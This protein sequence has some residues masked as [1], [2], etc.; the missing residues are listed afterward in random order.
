[1]VVPSDTILR[2]LPSLLSKG[3]FE[4]PYLGI[5]GQDITPGIIE[6]MKLPTGTHGT[7][8]VDVTANG[9]SDKAGLK[10]GT[11]TKSIDG[12]SIK[13]GGDVII[14]ADGM[15]MK[16]FYDL[17]VYLQR[18]KRPGMTV[19][20]SIIRNGAPM[21]IVVDLGTRPPP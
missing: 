17:I 21:N 1:M 2:E 16:N 4:H 20:L 3:T 12:V 8:I 11:T 10:G 7:L 18:N 5:Q 15:Q 19:N 6:A 13:I 9:P 14:S